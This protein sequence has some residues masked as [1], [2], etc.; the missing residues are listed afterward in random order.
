[1][2][3]VRSHAQAVPDTTKDNPYKADSLKEAAHL[4]SPPDTTGHKDTVTK[5]AAIKKT[6]PNPKRAGLYSAIFPGLGQ[7][8]NGQ[9]WKVPVVYGLL[10]VAGYFIVSNQSKYQE[11][12]KAYVGR[13]GGDYSKETSSTV[14]SRYFLYPSCRV[15]SWSDV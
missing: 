4:I 15:F 8:Y 11:Y 1:M 6:Q 13:L 10:G 12:R 3:S 14:T 5:V 7:L 9:Y 2:A